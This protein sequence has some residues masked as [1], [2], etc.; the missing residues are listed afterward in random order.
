MMEELYTTTSMI[1]VIDD[2]DLEMTLMNQIWI[3]IL[4]CCHG[5][6]LHAWLRPINLAWA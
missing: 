4:F 6:Y 5:F 2:K 1:F 3:N